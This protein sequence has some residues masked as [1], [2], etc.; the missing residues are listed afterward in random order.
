MIR[1]LA[2]T[3]LAALVA[4]PASAQTID[5]AQLPGGVDLTITRLAEEGVQVLAANGT[6]ILRAPAI[7]IALDLVDVGGQPAGLI[8][9]AASD[10]PACASV[11]YAVTLQ[12][13]SPW[14]RGP[15]GQPC[16]PYTAALYPGG[17]ILFSAPQLHTD[18]DAVLFDL[19]QGAYRLGPIRFA[20][21]PGRGWDALDAEVGGYS[22]LS[23]L[24]LY[25]AEP[26]YAALAALWGDGLF[27]FA[28]HLATRTVPQIEGNYL[29]QT[30]CLPAQCAFAIGM[31]AVDPA[32]ESIYAAYF[33]EGAPDIRPGLDEWPEAARAI[34]DTWR[35][36]GYR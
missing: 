30:G 5:V 33:N 20:P 28:Q 27:V 10:D 6:E 9:Q 11:P 18:G 22:D 31:L 8:V 19:E 29:L 34:Y 32:S 3:A 12:F 24:D 25:A 16:T 13:G 7:T 1:P 36:G 35:E 4:V 21:Q 26:V 14:L 15:I 2:A 17:A 23:S